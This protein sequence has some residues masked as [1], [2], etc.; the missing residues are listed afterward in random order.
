MS[1]VFEDMAREAEQVK[2][3]RLVGSLVNRYGE[4]YDLWQD[5]KESPARY[6]LI[7]AG[8]RFDYCPYADLAYLLRNKGF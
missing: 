6:A 4:V 5:T 7:K 1:T 2:R 3:C 8:E